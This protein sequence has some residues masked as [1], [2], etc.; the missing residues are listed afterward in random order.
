MTLCA[1]I[2]RY[3]DNEAMAFTEVNPRTSKQWTRDELWAALKVQ[4]HIVTEYQL[5]EEEESSKLISWPAQLEN[6]K[7]RWAIHTREWNAAIK[8]LLEL[9]RTFRGHLEEVEDVV[10]QPLLKR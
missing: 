8:D 5:M 3:L 7:V 2:L 6:L 9:G 1:T 4:E 10:R